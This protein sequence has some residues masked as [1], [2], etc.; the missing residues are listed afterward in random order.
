MRSPSAVLVVVVRTGVWRVVGDVATNGVVVVGDVATNGVV[1][2]ASGKALVTRVTITDHERT[3][4]SVGL[5]ACISASTR[6]VDPIGE[7]CPG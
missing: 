2:V 4:E 1:V 7:S 5:S 6:N 3:S